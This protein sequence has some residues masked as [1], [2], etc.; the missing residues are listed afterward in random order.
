MNIVIVGAGNIGQHA[1]KILSSE[2]KNVI[3]IDK[4]G[5][6]LEAASYRMDIATKKGLATDWQLLDDLIEMEPNLFVAVTDDDETEGVRIGG[7][8]S[9]GKQ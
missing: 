5:K 9:T 1:A 8:G 2:R 3:L 4:D 7:F 6:R